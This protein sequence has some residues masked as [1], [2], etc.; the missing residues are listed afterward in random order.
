VDEQENE[1]YYL[2]R[3][4]ALQFLSEMN[5]YFEIVLFTA[6]TPDYADWIIQGIDPDICITHRL[7]R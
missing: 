7:Y 6:A 2:I 3:P 4:G 5:K 1:G